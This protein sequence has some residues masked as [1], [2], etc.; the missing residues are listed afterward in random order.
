MR[1]SLGTNI[2]AIIT[3]SSNGLFAVDPEDLEVGEKL[4]KGGFG[5]D[6]IER[7]KSLISDESNIGKRF[8]IWYMYPAKQLSIALKDHI[9]KKKKSSEG[10]GDK[11][12]DET[13]IT[14]E[15]MEL[16]GSRCDIR[17]L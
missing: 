4:R 14:I 10:N 11:T 1:K 7:I 2:R 13:N 12:I 3:Q 16:S 5:L 15:E 6:E 8:D 9:K 17:F